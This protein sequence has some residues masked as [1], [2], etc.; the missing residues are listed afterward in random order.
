MQ[1]DDNAWRSSVEDRLDLMEKGLNGLFEMI[2]ELKERVGQDDKKEKPGE[3]D[4]IGM[5]A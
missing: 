1:K 4:F 2:E 5:K 3:R